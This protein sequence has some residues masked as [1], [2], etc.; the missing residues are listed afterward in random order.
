[1]LSGSTIATNNPSSYDS[2]RSPNIR[3]GA[4]PHHS[5]PVEI[6][7]EQDHML[8]EHPPPSYTQS[9]DPQALNLPSVP[10]TALPPIHHER[11]LPP[12]P[13]SAPAEQRLIPD[14][15][16]EPQFAWPSSNPLTAYYRP[17]PSQ[18]SPKDTSTS[19][20]EWPSAMDVDTPDRNRRG[21][22]VLSIDK[23]DLD[24]RIAAEALGELRAGIAFQGKARG[25]HAN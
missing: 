11:T 8:P 1:M 17:G 3:R 9:H 22:S 19:D 25:S 13:V 2:D 18:L 15:V 23:D 7:M 5:P 21:A 20:M 10:S 6:I 14:P 16:P 12:L 24:V 4:L